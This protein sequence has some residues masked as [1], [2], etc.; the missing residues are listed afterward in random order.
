[1]KVKN[2]TKGLGLAEKVKEAK[3]FWSR[4]L[5]LMGRKKL[6][7]SEA[8]LLYECNSIHSFFMRFRFDALFLDEDGKVVGLKEKMRPWRSTWIYRGADKT[9]E[10]EAGLIEKTKTTLGDRIV[11]F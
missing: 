8:L 11:F 3:G 7:D 6:E 2:E 10:M 9:L 5:G 1:M 4:F